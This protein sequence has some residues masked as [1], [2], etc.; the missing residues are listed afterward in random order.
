MDASLD[1]KKAFD[2]VE[3]KYLW[4]VLRHFGFG[5]NFISWVQIVYASLMARVCTGATR[6]TSFSLQRGKR[7]G[8]QLS[9]G[10]TLAIEPL[11]ILLRCSPVVHGIAIGPLEE[12]VSLCADHPLNIS[13]GCG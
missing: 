9:P 1:A 3:W 12:K 13:Q 5:P 2:W 11:S 4:A 7:R 8:C 6:S 10:F